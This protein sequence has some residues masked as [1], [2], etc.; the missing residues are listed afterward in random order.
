MTEFQLKIAD[1]LITKYSKTG[2]VYK[3]IDTNAIKVFHDDGTESIFRVVDGDILEEKTTV[4]LVPTDN[5]VK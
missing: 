1:Y 5:N 4:G 3:C 2:Y